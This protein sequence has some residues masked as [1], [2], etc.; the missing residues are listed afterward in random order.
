MDFRVF[1]NR[2]YDPDF[3]DVN[4]YETAFTYR[5]ALELLFTGPKTV[6]NKLQEM[7]DL[8]A[9][10]RERVKALHFTLVNGDYRNDYRIVQHLIITS[11]NMSKGVSIQLDDIDVSQLNIDIH[12]LVIWCGI[13]ASTIK[14]LT[15]PMSVVKVRL[16]GETGLDDIPAEEF[17]SLFENVT[18]LEINRFEPAFEIAASK[19]RALK[20]ILS[21]RIGDLEGE[22]NFPSRSLIENLP[23][24]LSVLSFKDMENEYLI[25]V[26]CKVTERLKSLTMVESGTYF[27]EHEVPSEVYTVIRNYGIKFDIS[28]DTQEYSEFACSEQ[29]RATLFLLRQRSSGV[30]N[31]IPPELVRVICELMLSG[32]RV[33]V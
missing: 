4:K 19:F 17:V 6:V 3:C 10:L 8:I 21:L 9:G 18:D 13:H 7:K 32:K 30:F 12:E 28:V 16:E 31:K 24:N 25:P 20:N 27:L 1:F 14:W 22:Y 2:D 15:S 23:E 5:G 33:D 26:I 11:P 29:V